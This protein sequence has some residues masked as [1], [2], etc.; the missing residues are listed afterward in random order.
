MKKI[1][2]Q[3]GLQII[4]NYDKSRKTKV[5]QGTQIWKSSKTRIAGQPGYSKISE[6]ARNSLIKTINHDIYS[7]NRKDKF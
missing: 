4:K 5:G 7:K 2:K 1:G 6:F 3:I